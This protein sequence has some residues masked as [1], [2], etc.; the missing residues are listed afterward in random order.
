MVHIKPLNVLQWLKRHHPNPFNVKHQEVL[1]F[2]DITS[3]TEKKK[4]KSKVEQWIWHNFCRCTDELV[5]WIHR[6]TGN[7]W[8][9]CQQSMQNGRHCRF[10]A[11]RGRKIWGTLKSS[12]I[13]VLPFILF[14]FRWVAK[15]YKSSQSGRQTSSYSL[16]ALCRECVVKI[17][18]IIFFFLTRFV[19][20]YFSLFKH[21]ETSLHRN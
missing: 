1:S 18:I 17:L 9:S 20:F 16:V 4:K 8:Y 12:K 10:Y 6:R 15:K 14:F 5:F 11:W 19:L 21:W 13:K 2:S 7:W 3:A